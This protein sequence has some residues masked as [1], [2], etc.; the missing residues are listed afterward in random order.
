MGSVRK[1][2]GGAAAFDPSDDSTFYVYALLGLGA[3]NTV[4]H[5][6]RRP[7]GDDS[8]QRTS[9]RRKCVDGGGCR[10]APPTA[11]ILTLKSRTQRS[12]GK[13]L[14]VVHIGMPKTGTT[15]LQASLAHST[16]KLAKLGVDYPRSLRDPGGTAHH[17]LPPELL[18][19]GDTSGPMVTEF[20]ALL[21]DRRRRAPRMLISSELFTSCVVGEPLAT[22][23]Q[24]VEKCRNH[25]PVQVVIA[26]RRIDEFLESMYLQLVKGGLTAE[27][28]HEFFGARIHWPGQLFQSLSALRERR[29]LADLRVVSFSKHS[30][31]LTTVLEACGFDAAQRG[32]VKD[33][34]INPR[35]GLKAQ[36]TLLLL[37]E[38]EA[39]VHR[40]V[41][42]PGLVE[43]FERRT[44]TFA[45]EIYD[46]R[47]AT[48]PQRRD[49][50]D[51][52]LRLARHYGIHE[53]VEASSNEP[54][55]KSP[56]YT[57]TR[58][59]LSRDDVSRLKTFLHRFRHIH[60]IQRFICHNA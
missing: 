51:E 48:P 45:D 30:S 36:T 8:I 40:S 57:M 54:A 28:P 18:A 33:A 55:R 15:S 12:G 9:G 16:A 60:R 31:F 19:R 20:L 58:S 7:A 56:L 26:L 46:Y 5:I 27:P 22:F 34:R 43:A 1:G 4:A 44:F 3:R 10:S 2:P 50:Q 25:R 49:V 14:L 52:S 47:V 59:L 21:A 38:L 39:E 41:W 17:S 6:V 11:S 35:L 13:R 29:D 23:L 24:F 53:Y 32:L 42:R 37:P